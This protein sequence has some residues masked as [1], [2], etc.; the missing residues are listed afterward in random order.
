MP[1]FVEKAE[2]LKS[3]GVAEILCISGMSSF[4]FFLFQ[5]MSSPP[6]S[7]SSLVVNIFFLI[8]IHFQ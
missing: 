2:E 4:S 6:L 5:S 1:G 8:I 3:K 7:T